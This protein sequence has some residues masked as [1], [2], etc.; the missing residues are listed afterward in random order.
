MAKFLLLNPDLILGRQRTSAKGW[1]CAFFWG[2]IYD[3]FFK[4]LF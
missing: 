1:A 3:L 2:G 4:L